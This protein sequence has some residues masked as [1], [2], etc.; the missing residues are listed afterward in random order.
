MMSI[1]HYDAVPQYDVEA[2]NYNPKKHSVLS[3][4]PGTGRGKTPPPA[5]RSSRASP[6][7][8]PDDQQ[9]A[10]SGL[11]RQKAP[12]PS[13]SPTPR[14]K[15]PKVYTTCPTPKDELGG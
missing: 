8:S 1:L 10:R 5:G 7:G 12:C 9:S 15:D 13:R 14:I 6:Q 11:E 3:A 2:D 4:M